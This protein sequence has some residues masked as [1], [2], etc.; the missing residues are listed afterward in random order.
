[1]AWGGRAARTYWLLAGVAFGLSACASSSPEKTAEAAKPTSVAAA[2]AADQRSGVDS[3]ALPSLPKSAEPAKVEA[4]AEKP[5][6]AVK[7]ATGPAK[8]PSPS[9]LSQGEGLKRLVGMDRTALESTLGMPW[10]LKREA[11][12]E[13]WQYRASNCVLDLFLYAKKDG[14]L[15]V[16]HADLRGRREGR[17]APPG[18]FAEIAAGDTQKAEAVKF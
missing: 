18:C 8:N 11:N 9:L 7:V 1:M 2:P 10:L 16:T 5:A 17:P 4:P 13:L 15:R 14:E 6:Q 3:A 12:A